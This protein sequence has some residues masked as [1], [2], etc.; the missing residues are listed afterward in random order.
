MS[1]VRRALLPIGPSPSLRLSPPPHTTS[2]SEMESFDQRLLEALAW[3]YLL[4]PDG[5]ARPFEL[6]VY[7]VYIHVHI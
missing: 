4:P 3:T 7:T 1:H 2:T 6:Y 5:T